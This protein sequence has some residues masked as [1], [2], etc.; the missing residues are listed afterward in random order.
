[1]LYLLPLPPVRIPYHHTAAT[2]L[3]STIGH[4]RAAHARHST[5]PAWPPAVDCVVCPEF[6]HCF[7]SLVLKQRSVD[8][9]LHTVEAC[10]NWVLAFLCLMHVHRRA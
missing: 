4:T 2:W 5:A 7:L 8:L 10:D 1:M 6:D 9:G 3:V